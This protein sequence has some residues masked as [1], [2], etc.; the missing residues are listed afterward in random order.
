VHHKQC[1]IEEPASSNYNT[2]CAIS[3]TT[4]LYRYLLFLSLHSMCI[5]NNAQ[6]RQRTCSMFFFLSLPLYWACSMTTSQLLP[7]AS[8]SIYKKGSTDQNKQISVTTDRWSNQVAR[9]LPV[10]RK[11]SN[12]T[13]SVDPL[14]Y[15]KE[16]SSARK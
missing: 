1:M 6:W 13:A 12:P 16:E 4:K 14:L 9:T 11:S 3:G 10:A 15:E 7:V 2:T 5:R 8:Y